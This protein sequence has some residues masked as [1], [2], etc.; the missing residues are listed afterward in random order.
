LTDFILK[1]SLCYLHSKTPEQLYEAGECRFELGGYFV[2][3]GQER[4]LLSQESL[5]SNMFYA[6][7]RLEQPSKDQVRT[8][9][10]KELKAVMDTATKENKFEF[11]AGIYSES[12]DG[13]KRAGHLLRIPPEN[14]NVTDSGKIAK[15]S[16]YGDFMT[17]RLATIQ[18][19]G[20][21]NPV[22]LISVF[23]ALGFTTDKDIYDVILAGVRERTLYDGLFAQLILSHE[24]YL[25]SEM[26]KEI[27]VSCEIID[28]RS[29]VPL[30]EEVKN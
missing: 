24:K 22:P 2:V 21:D 27:G 12:E 9:S 10:E 25:A 30:D 7:K 11:I 16:D 14:K 23:Y 3:S 26:A 4:V 13:S 6:K 17:N 19:P 8:R 5:G 1:S 28:I 20:F 29:I 18:L 15:T